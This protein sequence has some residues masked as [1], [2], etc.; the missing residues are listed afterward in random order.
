MMVLG[1]V[2]DGTWRYWVSRSWY[3]LVFGGTVSVWGG[4]V[5]YLVVLGQYYLVLLDIKCYLVSKG[6]SC[7]NILKE[8]ET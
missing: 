7:L 2:L 5:G 1:L 4:T 3:W 6:L 8:V